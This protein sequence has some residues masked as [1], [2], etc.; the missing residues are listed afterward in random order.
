MA[1]VVATC[2]SENKGERKKP[3][4]SVDCARITV[5]SAMPMPVTGTAR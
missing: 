1:Q 5:S 4:D 3:V 2:I